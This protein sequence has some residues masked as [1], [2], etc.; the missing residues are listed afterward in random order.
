MAQLEYNVTR[1][2]G[3][4]GQLADNGF[5]DIISRINDAPRAAQ[6]TTVTVTAVNDTDYALTIDGV[7]FEYTSDGSATED[8]IIDD[9]VAQ[10]N[11]DP[12]INPRVVASKSG[13]TLI[14]TAL[15]GG[16]GFEY[17]D[18]D[19]NLVAVAT[20]A[21]AEADTIDFGVLVMRNGVERGAMLASSANFTAQVD[22]LLLTYDAAVV[23]TVAITYEGVTYVVQHTQA[24]DA[25]TSIIALSD[26]INYVMPANTVIASHPTADTLTLTAE[27]PGA[28]FSVSYGFDSTADTAAFAYST[29]KGVA[30]SINRALGVT[31][32]EHS[33]EEIA[34]NDG[35]QYPAGSDMSVLR[36]G[37]ILVE[38][39]ESVDDGNDV[40]FG[41]SV[42]EAGKWRGSAAAGYLKLD[43]ARVRW[44]ENL[45]S[46]LAVL[47]VL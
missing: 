31:V 17:S 1:E 13:V 41:V 42:S 35:D 3:R 23:T 22:E 47:Q 18:D 39:E 36:S 40:F 16:I 8:E 46:S 15:T 38:T 27:V 11:A 26:A 32:R 37:R 25:D 5:H 33:H 6:I 4:K 10:I 43:S 7:L 30:T 34:Q 21:N 29:N 44:S 2:A 24:T 28:E 45:S 19:A 9:F 14:L 20:Q 12:L